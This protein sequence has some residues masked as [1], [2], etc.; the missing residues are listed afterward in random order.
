MKLQLIVGI[1]ALLMIKSTT[2]AGPGNDAVR[3][4]IRLFYL[5]LDIGTLRAVDQE[6]IELIGDRCVVVKQPFVRRIKDL[7]A[8]S[9]LARSKEEAFTNQLVRIK[10]WSES[11]KSTLLGVVEQDGRMLRN[12]RSFVLSNEAVQAL[13]KTIVDECFG[14]QKVIDRDRIDRTLESRRRRGEVKQWQDK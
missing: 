7:L 1:L 4:R 9:V 2:V 11:E 8:S 14:G 13:E 10:A 3:E 12:G 6:N 5:P